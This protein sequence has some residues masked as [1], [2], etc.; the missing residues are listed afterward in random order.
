MRYVPNLI[1]KESR[2]LEGY[3]K[4]GPSQ[5]KKKNIILE[6]FSWLFGIMSLL[7]ALVYLIHPILSIVLA[8]L[9][10]LLLP[11]GHKWVEKKLR[12]K[13]T[14]KIK[15]FTVA[16]L[17]ILAIP[18]TSHY[19]GIDKAKEEKLQLFAKA[20]ESKKKAQARGEQQRKDSLE[21]HLETGRTAI[22]KGQLSK[23]ISELDQAARFAASE[24][25]RGLLEKE[26]INIA[27][28]KSGEL[29]KAGKYKMALGELD[30]L[31]ANNP[32]NSDLLYNRAMCYSKT[33]RTAEAV[34]DCKKAMEIGSE[35]ARKL[36]EKIN[37]IRKRVAY[38]VTRCCDGS[39]SSATGRGACSH[40]GGVCDWNDP[41][42]EEYR[43]YE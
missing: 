10:F 24:G 41:V 4:I 42:Y 2:V 13:L 23:A 26:K 34:L 16:V 29:I 6:I 9:G 35:E 1:P 12:F 43:K 21:F 7:N 30:A 8:T 33:G 15:A 28:L 5:A 19:N 11:P 40:H 31:L 32:G 20:Q 38:Y 27:T 22:Q 37:P 18:L 14:T 25:D 36:H 3:F 17:L 39:T